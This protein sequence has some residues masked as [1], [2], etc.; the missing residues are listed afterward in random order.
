MN[1]IRNFI[2]KNQKINNWEDI[3]PYLDDLQNREIKSSEE[4]LKWWKD[5]SETDAFL[6]EEM[7]WR[8]IKMS[9]D[10]T[11]KNLSDSFNF[12]VS[13]IEPKVSEYADI[14]DKKF[15]NSKFLKDLDPEKYFIPV[16]AINKE[17]E[18]FRKENISL[19]AEMQ[20]KE[21]EYGNTVA[22]MTITFNNEEMTLQK[23]GN[24]LK[25][26]DRNVRKTVFELINERRF[27]DKDKLNDSLTDLI[28]I[29]HKI[30][31]NAG[32]NNYRDYKFAA[33][34]RFDY[35]VDDCITFHNSIKEFVVP[36]VDEIYKNRKEKLSL[37]K[38]KP[39][40]LEVDQ[41]N[42]EPLI[43][44][45]TSD[46]LLEKSI[47]VFSRI[48]PKYGDFLKI[49]KE[50]GYLD[51]ESRKGKSPGGFNYPLYES[52]IPFIFT[53]ATGNLRDV[54]T[55]MHEGGHAIHSFLSS[56]L[57]LVDF[58]GLTS[59]IAELASMS[60]ELISMSEWQVFFENKDDLIRAKR[61]QLEGIL[62]VL[63]WIA[64]VD[65]FQHLLYLAPEHT[66]EIREEMWRNTAK[67]FGS[68]IID[69]DGYEK[70]FDNNWQK[71]L[72]IF[73]VPFY[74]IEYG[75]AQLGAIAVWRN[76]LQNKETALNNFENALKL[77]YS[78]TIPET[79]KTAGIE[80]NFSKEYIS[81]LM[82]FVKSE[83]EKLK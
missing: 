75:F 79:Y 46:E 19:F 18:L 56:D 23:A 73:E 71:Q 20:Q 30:A 3:K 42:K 70:Y 45:K 50:N 38:L 10:T 36:F 49:M 32:F 11:D 77:G 80:F 81:E 55:L 8:Y 9:C 15:I 22:A 27:K 2:D 66:H 44:F 1:I 47:E 37:D 25:N 13:E 54:E 5:R 60:M 14:L 53:N 17:I 40:D 63:P 78:K 57:E 52:N 62:N 35:N 51:L 67:E 34:Q 33:L 24:F 6:E 69:W 76:F 83:L 7:A 82:E 16:R 21:Q 41:E 39:F 31:V 74:Y 43:P 72:H 12:F 58:K 4:L 64:N 48:R 61:H 29:R 26:T 28:S 65:K 59:E 68:E